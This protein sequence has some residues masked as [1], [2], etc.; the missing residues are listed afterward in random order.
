MPDL[1]RHPWIAGQARNDNTD[2]F[3]CTGVVNFENLNNQLRTGL[4]LEVSLT[5]VGKK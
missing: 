2:P 3:L 5:A 1:I 4:A